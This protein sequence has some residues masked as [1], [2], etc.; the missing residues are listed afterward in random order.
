MSRGLRLAGLVAVVLLV[1]AALPFPGARPAAACSCAVGTYEEQAER[2]HLVF[3]GVALEVQ[4]TQGGRLGRYVLFEVDRVW[5]G[6]PH[7]RVSL[8]TAADE[9][10]CGVD[11]DAGEDFL[12]FA[13]VGG[14]VGGSAAMGYGAHTSLCSGSHQ[15]PA[16]AE[17][18]ADMGQGTPVEP[19][20][21]AL[22]VVGPERWR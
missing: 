8:W 2:A 11:I 3:E 17:F 13:R 9:A 5:K 21:L 12:V 6:G 7:L 14:Y 22:A 15:A 4:G 10:Q 20:R 19:V 18:A 1:A 16:H